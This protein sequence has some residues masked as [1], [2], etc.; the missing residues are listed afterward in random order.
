MMPC[1]KI[2]PGSANRQAPAKTASRY[3]VFFHALRN[4][5]VGAWQPDHF[6]KPWSVSEET[7]QNWFTPILVTSWKKL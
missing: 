1:L 3:S 7:D 4:F 6:S 5:T 2:G